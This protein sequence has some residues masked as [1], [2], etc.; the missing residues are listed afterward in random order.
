MY[1]TILLSRVISLIGCNS[2]SVEYCSMELALMGLAESWPSG[3]LEGSCSE[4]IYTYNNEFDIM[5]YIRIS[6]Y[7]RILFYRLIYGAFRLNKIWS[8]I[9]GK[10]R[11]RQLGCP[12]VF[13]LIFRMSA[14]WFIGHCTWQPWCKQKH[15]RPPSWLWDMLS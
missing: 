2:M 6:E 12:G 8:V 4:Q 1:M 9:G 11:R 14:R 5:M 15:I 10:I 13:F 7:T 3:A